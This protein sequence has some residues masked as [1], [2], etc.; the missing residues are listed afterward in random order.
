MDAKSQVKSEI[1]ETPPLLESKILVNA[2]SSYQM[3]LLAQFLRN[4]SLT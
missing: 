2:I 3:S 1:K 4:F